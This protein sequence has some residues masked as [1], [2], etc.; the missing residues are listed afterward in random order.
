MR[1]AVVVP[2]L[3]AIISLGVAL[4]SGRSELPKPKSTFA[5]QEPLPKADRE[6]KIV[7]TIPIYK[8]PEPT[9]QSAV[10]LPEPRV[11]PVKVVQTETPR[12]SEPQRQRRE[13]T[14]S[15]ICARHNLRKVYTNGGRSWRCR[16]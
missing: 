4:A 3:A 11:A 10:P 7:R 9:V 1:L 6:T 8:L 16:K 12:R 13:R 5:Q 15:D 2:A 14:Y